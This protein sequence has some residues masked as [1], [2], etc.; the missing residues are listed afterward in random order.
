MSSILLVE[1][2]SL[3]LEVMCNIL[4][5]EGYEMHPA[6]NGKIALEILANFKP[7]LIISDIMMPE[8]DGFEFLASVRDMP[9]G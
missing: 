3:L 6:A 4:E 5:A 1:D 8:M 7:D 9:N 2:E